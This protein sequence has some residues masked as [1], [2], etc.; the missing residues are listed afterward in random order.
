MGEAYIIFQA[1]LK[2]KKHKFTKGPLSP[3]MKL[4]GI[5]IGVANLG[6]AAILYLRFKE[7]KRVLTAEYYKTS[8]ALLRA[9]PLAREKL[10]TPIIEGSLD[11]FFNPGIF[12]TDLTARF[13]VPVSGPLNKGVLYAWSSR[14]DSHDGWRIER[15]D[16]EINRD[17][18]RLSVYRDNSKFPSAQMEDPRLQNKPATRLDDPSVYVD[19][20]GDLRTRPN[21][22][23]C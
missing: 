9:F 3:L 10:G 20:K 13:I 2:M 21:G 23:D 6:L 8:M 4:S 17:A 11:V 5:A 12:S 15:L 1:C 22:D 14:E 7:R 18:L 19:M 16:L